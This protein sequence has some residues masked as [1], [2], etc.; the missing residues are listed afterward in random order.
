MLS[1][2]EGKLVA[3]GIV[4]LLLKWVNIVDS[5]WFWM[6][7][8]HCQTHEPIGTSNGS[9]ALCSCI[10]YCVNRLPVYLAVENNSDCS[11]VLAYM[12]CKVKGQWNK[13]KLSAH[14]AF[15]FNKNETCDLGKSK[16][17]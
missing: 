13:C 10:A 3:W 12:Y 14:F 8:Y 15:F 11:D 6:E 17:I 16:I 2:V 4:L 9:I 1:K 5:L 7:P